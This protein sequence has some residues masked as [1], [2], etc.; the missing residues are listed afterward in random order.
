M[1]GTESEVPMSDRYDAAI[2]FVADTAAESTGGE[3]FV[4]ETPIIVPENGKYAAL[5]NKV[6]S[7]C[8]AEISVEKVCVRGA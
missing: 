4:I 1:V 3:Y 8:Y 2:D 6:S 7:G 5:V